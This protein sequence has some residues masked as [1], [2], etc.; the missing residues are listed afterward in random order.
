MARITT[1]GRSKKEAAREET[2]REIADVV[3]PI[4]ES[5]DFLAQDRELPLFRSGDLMAVMSAGAY[6]FSLSSN[7]NSRPARSEV[8]VS[9]NKYEVIGRRETYED[10]IRLELNQ[11]FDQCSILNA[12]FSIREGISKCSFFPASGLRVEH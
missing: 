6:G 2:V 11:E 10:L 7:Y 9:G 8:L 5:A 3:G 12:Q 4:C 1:S